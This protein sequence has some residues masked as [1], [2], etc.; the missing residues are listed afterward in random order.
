MLHRTYNC[1]K[2]TYRQARTLVD[3]LVV[4]VV[5]SP[6]DTLSLLE[7][8]SLP[9][10]CRL[11]CHVITSRTQG[12]HHRILPVYDHASSYRFKNRWS[13]S[14]VIGLMPSLSTVRK[15]CPS[16]IH[17]QSCG[18]ILHR[19]EAVGSSGVGRRSLSGNKND[20]VVGKCW[21][22]RHRSGTWFTTSV[23]P[24]LAP[25]YTRYVA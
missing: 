17:S 12:T 2:R 22:L 25:R 24:P 14:C 20:Q 3:F 10:G 5:S 13:F 6:A 21:L 23:S 4:A 7:A 1:F 18:W 15:Q 9:S 19:L 8:G 16:A 11:G